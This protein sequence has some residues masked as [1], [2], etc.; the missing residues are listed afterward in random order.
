MTHSNTSASSQAIKPEATF[1]NLLELVLETKD[2]TIKKNIEKSASEAF[3]ELRQMWEVEYA[4]NSFQNSVQGYA[5]SAEFIDSII[6]AQTKQSDGKNL[7]AKEEDRSTD[8]VPAL[9]CNPTGV[10]PALSFLFSKLLGCG[11]VKT[12]KY[13]K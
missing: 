5:K 9:R 11:D 10:K 3:S 8:M 1:V 12:V 13:V 6:K 4:K 2:E 7:D